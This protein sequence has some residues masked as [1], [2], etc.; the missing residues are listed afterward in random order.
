LAGLSA[1]AT[2]QPTNHLFLWRPLLNILPTELEKYL[3]E[4]DITWVED[5]SNQNL[6][7]SRNRIRYQLKN[8]QQSTDLPTKN[9]LRTPFLLA[10]DLQEIQALRH[11]FYDTFLQQHTHFDTYWFQQIPPVLHRPFLRYWLIQQ[12]ESSAPHIKQKRW[13]AKV[14]ELVLAQ[15]PTTMTVT[16]HL[17]LAFDGQKIEIKHGQTKTE[18]MIYP[19]NITLPHVFTD[20]DKSQFPYQF[21]LTPWPFYL[22]VSLSRTDGI[23]LSSFAKASISI[24]QRQG[25]E[26]IK[27]SPKRPTKTLKQLWQEKGTPVS[28]RLNS[29]L[30]YVNKHLWS[31]GELPIDIDHPNYVAHQTNE[32]L[33]HLALQAK[34]QKSN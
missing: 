24:K 27:P 21:D 26:T 13:I 3:I 10:E 34:T 11:L 16:Q 6:A 29:P 5:P 33:V 31:A 19:D 7:F 32:V 14:W 2:I 18:Q 17:F 23:P 22:N 4:K 20:V 15:K 25:G 8:L 9:L 1:M 12:L 30:I 28:D